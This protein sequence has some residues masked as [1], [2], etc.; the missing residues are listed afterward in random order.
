MLCCYLCKAAT[1]GALGFQETLNLSEETIS[2]ASFKN[3]TITTEDL[4]EKERKTMWGVL[5]FRVVSSQMLL[6]KDMGVDS[7]SM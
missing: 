3:L 5:L 7:S 4:I 6:I 1:E 2:I